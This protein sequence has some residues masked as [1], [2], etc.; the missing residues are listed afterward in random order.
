MQLHRFTAA[1]LKI[2]YAH[3]WTRNGSIVYRLISEGCLQVFIQ[4]V[5]L[6]NLLYMYE[7]LQDQSIALPTTVHNYAI[8]L[9]DS[10]ILYQ[11][12]PAVVD[13]PNLHT[14]N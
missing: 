14:T 7:A 6:A 13:K 5:I 9:C 2:L 4:L 12:G 8:L 1:Q 11:L 3:F 10:A